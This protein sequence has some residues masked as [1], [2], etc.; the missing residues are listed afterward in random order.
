MRKLLL[1]I[2]L[3]C[4]SFSVAAIPPIGKQ[5]PLFSARDSHGVEVSLSDFKGEVV[6]LEWTNHD[7]PFVRKHYETGNMQALQMEATKRGV[8]WL[9]IISSAP[10]KQG[11]VS[12]EEANQL[13]KARNASPDHVIL[14]PEGRIGR[15]YD[16]RT[17][18]HMY[19]IDEQGRLVFAGGIDDR[20]SHK[21]DTVKSAKN[22]VLAALDELASG[23][24]ITTP[25]PRPYGCSVKYA[26]PLD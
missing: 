6:V 17:T 12:G 14:D 25:T 24:E 18:P 15:L 2:G 11:Y 8:T 16:A 3:A 26:A 7:C 22:H 13:T 1:L 19:I 9:S 20:P 5:A 10:G 4:I 21:H 23:K